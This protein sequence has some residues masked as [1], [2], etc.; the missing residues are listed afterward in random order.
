MRKAVLALVLPLILMD[1]TSRREKIPLPPADPAPKKLVIY[2]LL[3]RLF[4]NTQAANKPWGTLEENGVGKF[5]DFTPRAFSAIKELGVTHMWYTGVIEHASLNGYPSAGVEPD[6]PE[7]VKGRA[8]SPFTIRDYYDVDPDLATDVPTRMREFESL[9]QRTHDA[10]LGVIIDFVPNHV[11]RRYHSDAKPEG[12]VDLGANDDQRQSF[13]PSNNFYYLP[14]KSFIAPPEHVKRMKALFPDRVGTFQE[15]PAKVTSDD[16]FTA[17]PPADSWFEAVKLNY[18]VDY[19]D[20]GKK[21]M[22]PVPDTWVKMKDILIYWTQKGVDGFR[23][24]M[25]EMVPVEFWKWAI[26]HVKAIN[27]EVLFIAE[28]YTPA[29]YQV[30]LEDGRFDYLYDKVQLYDTLRLLVNGKASARAVAGIRESQGGMHHR[31][32]HFM[33]NHDE[34]RIA[35][36]FFAGDAFKGLPAMLVSATIDAGPVMIYFGQEVGEPGAGEE[37]FSPRDG[38][39]SYFDYWGVPEHQKW[40]NGGLFDGGQLSADQQRLR[41]AYQAILH[42]ARDERAIREG[43]YCD[44]TQRLV[45]LKASSDRVVTFARFTDEECILVVA[46]FNARP[47]TVALEL[48][49]TLAEA[50]AIGPGQNIDF[51]DLLGDSTTVVLSRDK[52]FTVSIPPYGIRMFKGIK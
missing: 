6:A 31:L 42:S 43:N 24:D 11:A 41:A 2:Q 52:S 21:H 47:E 51:R 9:V 15:T 44:L 28:I 17:A 38:R 16:R 33:E 4:G 7:I 30:Y 18:G 36:P 13:L 5:R 8:G 22:D 48:P 14:G 1:C 32:L 34:Q 25:A 20:G 12:V 39:T 23:C 3:P 29:R 37:G 10:G 45:G 26:P 35:S 46:G 40:M 50:W 19:A 49:A 27:P